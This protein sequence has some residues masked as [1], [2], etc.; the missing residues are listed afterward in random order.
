MYNNPMEIM[1]LI[2]S[3]YENTK[4][5]C[6]YSFLNIRIN[7]SLSYCCLY[8]QFYETFKVQPIIGTNFEILN[9]HQYIFNGFCHNDVELYIIYD[10][11]FIFDFYTLLKDYKTFAVYYIKCIVEYIVSDIKNDFYFVYELISRIWHY[12]NEEE[13]NIIEEWSHSHKFKPKFWCWM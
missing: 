11:K 3:L 6:K 8:K 5:L 10:G 2:D 12:D 4:D 7:L 9:V 13:H 1:K